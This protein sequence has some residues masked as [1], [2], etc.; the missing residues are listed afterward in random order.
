MGVG[1]PVGLAALPRCFF[2]V[3]T[4]EDV[5]IAAAEVYTLL[6]MLL[7]PVMDCPVL[8]L[9]F[10][11][12]SLRLLLSS[13]RMCVSFALKHVAVLQDRTACGEG[14]PQ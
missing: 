11:S 7:R 9:L 12:S 1:S 8:P 3:S 2:S 14:E 5:S 13:V 6:L 10:A 4:N